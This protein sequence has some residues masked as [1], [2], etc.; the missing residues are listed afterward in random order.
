MCSLTAHGH[1]IF[2][3]NG[4]LALPYLLSLIIHVYILFTYHVA[5]EWWVIT[6]IFRYICLLACL[7][8]QLKAKHWSMM[9]RPPGSTIWISM[10]PSL[11]LTNDCTTKL[12]LLVYH[13]AE[14]NGILKISLQKAL[15]QF[16]T[17]TKNVFLL[18]P[19]AASH[20][21]VGWCLWQFG[22]GPSCHSVLNP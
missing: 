21:E 22:A 19:P 10:I 17:K 18:T 15:I 13:L 9:T 5:P 12:A 2:A 11:W 6:F 7:R 1:L 8:W 4:V 20:S 16:K 14:E 3:I